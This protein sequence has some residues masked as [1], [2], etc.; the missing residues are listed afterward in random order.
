MELNDDGTVL[1]FYARVER[2]PAVLNVVIMGNG[3]DYCEV[4]CQDLIGAKNV[5]FINEKDHLKSNFARLADLVL[6]K[7]SRETGWSFFRQRYFESYLCGAFLPDA[8][9]LLFVFFDSNP[10]SRDTFFLSYLK[11]K[12]QAKLILYVMNPTT[13]IALDPA[14]CRHFYDAVFTVYARDADVFGWRR[15]S[16]LYSRAPD[17]ASSGD[18]RYKSDVFFAGRAKDRLPSLLRLYEF[19]TSRQV[20]CDFHICD[21]DEKDMLY[22]GDITYNQWL[23][24]P[25]MLR[26]MQHSKCVLE[27]LQRPGEGPTLRMIEAVVYNKKI[28]TND[29][30]ASENPFYDARF[31]HIFDVPGN[32]DLRFIRDETE[33][34]FAYR[35]EYSA[36]NLIKALDELFPADGYSDER[37]NGERHGR[38]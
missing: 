4:M 17:C 11:E 10:H 28:L 1:A 30:G 36:W 26:R 21:V 5:V 25:D 32:L 12:C 23:P 19:L 13:A 29:A 22:A 2:F 34:D 18:R 14:L 3:Q 38:F 9:R 37:Q 24:Y 33:P 6:H 27:M 16:H 20:K 35:G 7:I 15:L 8:P 31:M